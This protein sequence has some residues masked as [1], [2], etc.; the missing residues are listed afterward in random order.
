ME[1]EKLKN[2]LESTGLPV[3]YWA[4]PE[5]EAPP[6]P[7]VC[8]LVT[9]SNPLFADGTTYFSSDTVQ[10]ELYTEVKDPASEKLVETAMSSFHPKKYQEYLSTEQCWMTTYEIEV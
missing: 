10:I 6:L 7:Y 3:A 8:Y 5:R 1:L 9:G 2:I 4:F